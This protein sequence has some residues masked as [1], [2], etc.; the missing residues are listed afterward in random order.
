MG[1]LL[2]PYPRGGAFAKPGVTTMQR[3][4][5]MEMIETGLMNP[6]DGAFTMG[7]ERFNALLT[8]RGYPGASRNGGLD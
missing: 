8:W 6:K 1:P 7:F 2:N 4:G 5:Q 3:F